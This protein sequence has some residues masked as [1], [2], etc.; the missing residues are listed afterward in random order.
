MKQSRSSGE[1]ENS[2]R[3]Y[4]QKISRELIADC[5]VFLV[6]KTHAQSTCERKLRGGFHTISCSNWV[7]IIALTEESQV[8]LVEQYRHGIG[9]LTLEI[10]GGC[11]DETDPDPLTAAKR[12]LLEET[13]FAS[14][15]WNLLG[16]CYPNPALQD[17]ICYTFLAEN[18]KQI[19]QPK[20]DAS[21][22][23]SLQCHHVRLSDINSLIRNATI[24]HSLV[25][26]AFQYLRLARP[27]LGI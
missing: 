8:I 14:D 4:W 17:N 23:E 2:K 18:V 6:H 11:I 20:F 26:A 25:L 12:E 19:E 24:T 21:G 7:N 9:A 22:T 13:G 1:A 5:E 27:S 15:N 10:P 3:L 16:Q